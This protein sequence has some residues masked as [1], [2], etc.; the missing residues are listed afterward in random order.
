MVRT[1]QI[2]CGR[3]PATLPQQGQLL[4]AWIRSNEEGS[5]HPHELSLFPPKSVDLEAA[6]ALGLERQVGVRRL[7]YSFPHRKAAEVQLCRT[8]VEAQWPQLRFATSVDAETCE[9]DLTGPEAQ[10]EAAL[11]FL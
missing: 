10:M 9:V 1:R 8:Q 11:D 6:L 2:P 4:S 5:N 7:H 3:N